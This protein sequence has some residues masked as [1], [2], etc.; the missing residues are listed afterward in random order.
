LSSPTIIRNSAR[1]RPRSL[2]TRAASWRGNLQASLLPVDTCLN[3]FKHPS[4]NLSR[5]LRQFAGT[6]CPGGVP[7][8][9]L[10]AGLIMAAFVVARASSSTSPETRWTSRTP[11]STTTCPRGHQGLR[12]LMCEGRPAGTTADGGG[13]G[14]HRDGRSRR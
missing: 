6:S 13:Q 10:C 8:R 2:L 3:G 7:M 12:D 4:G 14:L 5:V 1:R 9:Q 11:E